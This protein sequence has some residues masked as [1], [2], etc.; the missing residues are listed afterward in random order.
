MAKSLPWTCTCGHVVARVEARARDQVICHCRY[1]RAFARHLGHAKILDAAG[2]TRLILTTPNR[3]MIDSGVTDLAVLRLS[4]RGPFR[5]YAGCCHSPMI[6]V[7]PN[8]SI[9]YA[10]IVAQGFGDAAPYGKVFRVARTSATAPVAQEGNGFSLAFGIAWRIVSTWA[11]GGHRQSP[12]FGADGT[13]PMPVL[14]LTS[15]ERA[16]VLDPPFGKS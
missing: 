16:C 2:G 12:F 7:F 15:Q 8:P 1:C 4:R 5:W 14:R 6:N 13:P 11:K 3:V 9:A 10:S